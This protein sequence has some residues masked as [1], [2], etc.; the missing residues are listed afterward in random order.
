MQPETSHISRIFHA[1]DTKMA[2]L[3]EPSYCFITGKTEVLWS[4][5]FEVKL[6]M[7]IAEIPEAQNVLMTA[8]DGKI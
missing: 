2:R 6:D 4:P 7:A 1:C 8:V 5:V 3:G